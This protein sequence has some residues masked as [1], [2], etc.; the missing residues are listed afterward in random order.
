MTFGQGLKLEGQVHDVQAK[1]TASW[2]Q[3]LLTVYVVLLV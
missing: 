2:I 3:S 1:A